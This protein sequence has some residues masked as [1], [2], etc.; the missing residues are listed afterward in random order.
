[1]GSQRVGHDFTHFTQKKGQLT[2]QDV[3]IDFTQEEWECLDLGQRELYRDVMLQNYGN[4]A[5]LGLV[6]MLDLVAFL[7]QLKDPRSMRRMETTAI[8]PAMSSQDTQDLMLKNPVLEDIFPKAN[9]GIYQIFHLRNLNLMKD[10]EYTRVY[11]RQRGCFYGH[12]EMETV[13]HNANIT[14]KRNEQHESN[15]EKQQLQSSTSDEKYKCLRKDFHPSLKHTYSLKGH[16]ENLESNLVSTANTHSDNSERRLRLNIHSRMSE[17]LQLNNEWEKSQSNQFEG[18]V[19]RGSF[20]FPQQIFSLH[21]KMYNVDDNGGNIIQPSLFNT[22]CDVVNTQQLSI[23]NKMSQTLSK[24]S[25][26]NNYK[27]INGGLRRYSGNENGYRVEGDSNLVKHKGS[28][29]SNKD[30]KSNKCRNT[31]DQMSDFSLDKSNCTEETTCTEYGKVSN[32]SSELTQQQTVQNPQKEKKCKICGKVFSNSCHLGRHKKIHTGRKPFKCT[33]CTKAFN[34]SS[35]LTKHQR[36]HTG[37]KPYKCTECG[38]R[39]NHNSNLIQHWRIHTGEKPY[40]CTECSKAFI[41]SSHLIYHQQIHTGERPYKCTECSKAFICYSQLTYHQRIHTGEKPYKCTECSKA[42]IRS[43]H[44]TGHQRI[45]SGERPYKCKE[46]NKAFIHRS[47]LTRHQRIHTGEKPYKCKECNKAFIR[48][49]HLTEHQQIHTGERPYKCKEC[50]KAFI[51]SSALTQHHRI[52]TWDRCYK[53]TEIGKAFIKVSR[54]T[55]H[56]RTHTGERPYK[57]TECGRTFHRNSILTTHLRVHTGE[58]PYK[59][60]EC[61]K[62]FHRPSLLTRHQLIHSGERPYKCKECN[63]AFIQCSH[64]TQHQRIHT[65]ER[66]YKC[67]ECGKAFSHSS[68]LT[69]HLRTHT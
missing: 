16:V 38:K 59:C 35:L 4:L 51:T 49:S 56:Q 23:C 68:N 33:E 3:A 37:E 54:V 48:C 65:G 34:H 25:S 17:H 40:K 61:N 8:Y 13:T 66:P 63:K 44:L 22:Y 21:S 1:M 47:N 15:W 53:G 29:S 27:S 30:S 58:K 55:K 39:F 32:Q 19:S 5:S 46:C 43:S 7:E 11:E 14:A 10:W 69:K 6:S 26:S 2:F 9:L 31:F 20:F 57:C 24:S 42:F 64:L 41:C 52:H 50:G 28:K 18:S 36:I 62:A 60:K 67:T 45:H 12:K